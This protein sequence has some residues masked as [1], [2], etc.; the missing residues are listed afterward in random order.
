MKNTTNNKINKNHK[1]KEIE[2][3]HPL[4]VMTQNI[5]GLNLLSK[6]DQILQTMQ[7]NNIDI[8][9]LAETKLTDKTSKHFYKNNPQYTSYFNNNNEQPMGSGVGIIFQKKYANK[10]HRVQGFKGRIIYADMYLK[11]NTKIRI[12]QVYLHANFSNN[13]TLIE[14][15]RNKLIEY[16]EDAQRHNFKLIIMGDFNVDPEKYKQGYQTTGTFHWKYKILYDLEMKDLVDTVN[17][18]QDIT[19]QNNYATF[20]PKQQ[21]SSSSRIDLIWISRDLI[22]ETLNSNN[23]EPNLYSTDHNAVFVS[24]LTNGLF[25]NK[26]A[27]KLRQQK[28]RKRI[29]NYD[30]MDDDKWK[31]FRNATESIVDDKFLQE[32]KIHDQKDL[33]MYWNDISRALLQVAIQTIDN[34]MIPATKK[35]FK[36]KQLTDAYKEIKV[37]NKLINTLSPKNYQRNSIYVLQDYWVKKKFTVEAIAASH[38]IKVNIPNFI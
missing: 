12:I 2:K 11:G 35:E 34:H 26:Q 28:I 5:Q 23:Y 14:E 13:K 3:Q 37:I 32:L 10:I 20:I 38:V 9:G 19:T 25:R 4:R 15:T 30:T 22:L 24:F 7:I 17:L 21:T 18:Y 1:I 16:V 8:V 33:T 36:P 31:K 29:F 27:A 6:R